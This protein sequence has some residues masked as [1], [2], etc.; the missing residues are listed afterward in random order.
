MAKPKFIQRDLSFT[1]ELKTKINEYFENNKINKTGNWHLYSKAIILVVALLA[2]YVHLVFF[3]PPVALAIIECLLLGA[4]VAGIGFNVMHDGGHGSF[5]ENKTLNNFASYSLDF[6]G[7]SSF[8]WNMKHNVIH[9]TYTNVEGYDDDIEAGIFLRLAASQPKYKIHK[10]QHLYFWAMYCVIY[11]FWIFFLDFQK[12]FTRKIGRV[13]ISK[14]SLRSH[15]G[16]WSSKLIFGTIF[17]A[18]PI[19]VLGIVPWAIGFFCFIFFTGLLIALVFQLAHTVEH[20]EM[21]FV[22]ADPVIIESEWTVHQLRTT[23]NFATKN[24]IVNWFTGG[25]N[26]QVEHHLFPR[27]S[28]VHYPAISKILKDLCAKYDVPYN[29]YKRTRQAIASHIRFLK[30]MGSA[31]AVFRLAS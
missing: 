25:L 12:Y 9:H 23:A 6:L 3:T 28:H 21:V 18:I 30:E 11:F 2:L 22:D 20:T 10:Y 29:E 14:M 16:F 7:G 4:V 5:S 26:F 13:E 24:K 8:M 1:Q 27:I 31:P 17:M 19:Y 15:F